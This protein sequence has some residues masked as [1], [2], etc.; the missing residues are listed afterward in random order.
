MNKRE[1]NYH[2][3]RLIR[4]G[5]IESVTKALMPNDGPIRMM[6]VPPLTPEEKAA[7]SNADGYSYTVTTKYKQ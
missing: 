2:R 7:M 6:R 5:L 3:Y 1:R 4:G